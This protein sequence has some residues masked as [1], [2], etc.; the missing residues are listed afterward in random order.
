MSNP[1]LSEWIAL[2][3]VHEGG[4]G[5]CAGAYFEH[6]HP[7]PGQLT[8]VFDRLSWTG[9]VAVAEGDPLWS[10]RQLSITPAGHARYATLCTALRAQ[11]QQ[12]DM[13]MPS[14]E[15]GTQRETPAECR[16]T[17]TSQG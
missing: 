12:S 11:R 6:G 13:P 10:L 14:A 8:A 7:V 16:S 2:H 15:F 17:A 5:K 1:L 4:V 9:L 3:R